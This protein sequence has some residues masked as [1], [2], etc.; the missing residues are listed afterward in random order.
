MTPPTLLHVSK[1]AFSWSSTTTTDSFVGYRKWQLG[2][3]P[4]ESLS[5]III[6]LLH[7]F[8]AYTAVWTTWGL[9]TDERGFLNTDI[10]F[11]DKQVDV[12]SCE[13]LSQYFYILKKG[14]GRWEI[15]INNWD[16][17]DLVKDKN[18]WIKNQIIVWT[19]SS[20]T[21]VWFSLM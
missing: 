6:H 2:W 7:S 15:I 13:F 21:Y 11:F 17:R 5:L 14:R 12:H 18:S 16:L 3:I 20:V 9:E 10:T 4:E 19:I 1:N 8:L